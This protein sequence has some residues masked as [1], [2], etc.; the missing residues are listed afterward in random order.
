MRKRLTHARHRTLAQLLP[1]PSRQRTPFFK[2]S[3]LSSPHHDGHPASPQN[4]IIII[5][6]IAIFAL[7]KYTERQHLR[8]ARVVVLAERWA[9]KSPWEGVKACFLPLVPLAVS[10]MKV[11]EGV[12]AVVDIIELA[13]AAKPAE[14]ARVAETVTA[15]DELGGVLKLWYLAVALFLYVLRSTSR[16]SFSVRRRIGSCCFLFSAAFIHFHFSTSIVP[17][18]VRHTLCKHLTPKLKVS[19]IMLLVY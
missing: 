8:E 19:V 3:L 6:Y 12:E 10:I 14:E 16:V 18:N 11:E 15:V 13:S 9:N 1:D 2:D 4:Q 5:M 7:I 17:E